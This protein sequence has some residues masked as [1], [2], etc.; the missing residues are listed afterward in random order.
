L[1]VPES[2][3]NFSLGNCNTIQNILFINF[4]IGNFMIN[5]SGYAGEDK[6]IYK[7]SKPLLMKFRSSLFQIIRTV[8]LSPFMIL[9][10]FE[11][12]QILSVDLSPPSHLTNISDLTNLVLT[13]SNPNI[14]L[15][16]ANLT[17]I[18]QLTGLAYYVVNWPLTTGIMITNTLFGM[19]LILLFL[20]Y[21]FVKSLL[22]SS[23]AKVN[24]DSE[25]AQL[26]GANGKPKLQPGQTNLKPHLDLGFDDEEFGELEGTDV[27][28]E[29]EALMDNVKIPGYDEDSLSTSE[30][31]TAVDLELTSERVAKDLTFGLPPQQNGDEVNN[32]NDDDDEADNADGDDSVTQVG[33][34][35]G[36]SSRIS[37]NSSNAEENER[38]DRAWDTSNSGVRKRE[39]KE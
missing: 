38:L 31:A 24:A 9:G 6:L 17:L 34:S 33:S 10:Y 23:K 25:D 15:E 11:E 1:K 19:H 12:Y 27:L 39:V 13:I 16:S 22:T 28:K 20:A 37:G 8:V 21:Q 32:D 30:S 35:T 18:T 14:Q 2:V 29:L 5:I 4:N 7:V 36:V 26:S 3:I